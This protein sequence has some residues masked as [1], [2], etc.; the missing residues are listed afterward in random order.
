MYI[1]SLYLLIFLLSGVYK[2]E[3]S[4]LIIGIIVLLFLCKSFLALPF[5]I[6]CCES[7]VET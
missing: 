3:S 5:M 2:K 7:L 4:T 1:R 6:H